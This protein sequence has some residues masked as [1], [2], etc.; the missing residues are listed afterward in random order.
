M[1]AADLEL[2]VRLEE[3]LAAFLDRRRAGRRGHRPR[4]SAPPRATCA[5]SCWAAASA[6]A[7]RSRGGAGAARAVDPDGPAVDAVLRAVSALE[8]IQACALVHD[9]LMDA[10]AT[11]PRP[12]D[13]ARRLRPPAR[14][15]GVARPAR[16]VRRRGRHPARRPRPGLGR[17]HAARCRPAT[18]TPP[19]ARRPRGRRCA[20]RCSAGSTS[21]CFVQSTGDSSARA[22]LQ[23]DR[24]KTA[25]YTVE[26]PLHLG[27]AIAGA[28]PD[29]VACYRRFGADIGV[30]FQLRDDLLGVFGDPAVTGKP[31]GDD[32]REGKRTLLLALAVERAA[33]RGATAAVAEIEQAV[34]DPGA[35]RRPP[36]PRPRPARRAGCRPGR[37]AAHRRAHRLGAR[38]ARRGRG[39]RARRVPARRPGR[40]GHPAAP[41][42]RRHGAHGPRRGG[43]RGLLRAVRR[44]APARRRAPRHARRTGRP[45]GR[46]GR[47][48]GP[49][50]GR[51]HL[52]GRPRPDGADHAVAARGGVRRRRGEAR[53]AAGPRP[54]RSRL[55]RALRRR[56][57]D[58][59][60]H[61]RRRHGGRDPAGLRAGRRGGLRPAAHLADAALPT[62]RSTASSA[63]TSTRRSACSDRTW[64]GWPRSAGSAGSPR[65]SPGTC[66]TSGCSGSSPSRPSTR[67]C[68]RSGRSARTA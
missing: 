61:R 16:P 46:P 4:A 22:A 44:A 42:K 37:R 14:R 39:G 53:G 59:R 64:P 34:G 66:P 28:D 65:G 19:R 9:D 38:R 18:P 2:P 5:S 21:T 67:A 41:V 35:R 56:V 12:P 27:A 60:P 30:A 26:R 36:R 33:Q 24:Y 7:R 25:A 20:R 62:P 50:D 13:R 8:L 55:P 63:R 17:R 32:L 6:S 11:A 31:A 49:G 10:S 47:R 54:A 51:G 57:H 40:G 1:H 68:R 48:A 52:P 58:R 3:T 15:R 45:P 29:L 43:R 23:I